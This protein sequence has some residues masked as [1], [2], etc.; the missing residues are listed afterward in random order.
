MI[1]NDPLF[2]GMNVI[3]FNKAKTGTSP[4]KKKT[5]L[6]KLL[7]KLKKN[8]TLFISLLSLAINIV[9]LCPLFVSC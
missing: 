5:F 3:E 2:E 7:I 6:I 4:H 1:F 8:F 9:R